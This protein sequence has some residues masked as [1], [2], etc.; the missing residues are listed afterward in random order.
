MIVGLILT[1]P[2]R[3]VSGSPLILVLQKVVDKVVHWQR[4]PITTTEKSDKRRKHRAKDCKKNV[5]A[6]RENRPL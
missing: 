4:V 3:K 2:I 5:S 6:V 1:F